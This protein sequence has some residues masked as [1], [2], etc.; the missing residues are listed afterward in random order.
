MKGAGATDCPAEP[1]FMGQ[2]SREILVCGHRQL[3]ALPVPLC[4]RRS[5]HTK[6]AK[7]F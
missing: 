6:L 7:V 1:C 5:L 2:V 3:Q 4:V